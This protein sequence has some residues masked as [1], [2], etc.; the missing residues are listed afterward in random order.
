MKTYFLPIENKLKFNLTI[1]P[2]DI[3]SLVLENTV[4]FAS[5]DIVKKSEALRELGYDEKA[6]D[7]L[8]ANANG[9]IHNLG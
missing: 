5:K 3:F 4:I 2:I 6:L 7:L 8:L 1:T 9:V